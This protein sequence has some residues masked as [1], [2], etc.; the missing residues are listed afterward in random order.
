VAVNDELALF[1]IRHAGVLRPAVEEVLRVGRTS[2]D[3]K[4]ERGQD[5]IARLERLLAAIDGEGGGGL[6]D[7]TSSAPVVS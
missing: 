2:E 6:P 3:G 4:T 1:A 7:E 5:A